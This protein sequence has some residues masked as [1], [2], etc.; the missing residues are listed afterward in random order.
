MIFFS[1]CAV[2]FTSLWLYV[3][4]AGA[5]L[6]AGIL[7]IFKGKKNRELQA[8]QEKL[9]TKTLG[10]IW[11]V[12]HIWI[13]LVIVILFIAFPHFFSEFAIIYHIPL[14][15]ILFGIT[16]RGSAFTFR[17]Y[18]AIKDKWYEVYSAVFA[19]SSL[20]TV[21]WFGII[22]GSLVLGEH[23]SSSATFAPRFLNPWFQPFPLLTG[24]FLASLLAFVA[25]TFLLAETPT[26]SLR[27]LFRQRALFANALAIVLGLSL[28][29]YAHFSHIFRLQLLF[30]NVYGRTCFLVSMLLLVPQWEAVALQKD[31]QLRY[32]GGLQLTL[33]L[34]GLLAT[35]S[36]TLLT[37]SDGTAPILLEKTAAVPEA[38]YRLLFIA[39]CFGLV[40][41]LPGYFYLMRL[42]YFPRLQKQPEKF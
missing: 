17:H 30:Q 4:L 22:V 3:L 14:T 9:I 15:A 7:E 23:T 10:P 42:F 37:Y 18:D 40:V 33:V 32:F 34:V 28:F 11:E 19:W 5:D 38:T 27:L 2:L 20:W 36:P 26:P 24:F 41:I 16:A 25:A 39:L 6:G 8:E 1:V 13:I 29:A 12:N 31:R 21:L 35:L